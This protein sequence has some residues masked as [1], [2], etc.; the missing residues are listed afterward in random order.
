MCP[1]ACVRAGLAAL[2]LDAYPE[3]YSEFKHL[4]LAFVYDPESAPPSVAELWKLAQ[5][6]KLAD[7]LA[8]TLKQ[9][10]GEDD[11]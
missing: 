7:V 5:R 2:A 10:I 1:A 11:I 3:A 6:N 4:M 9:S 8:A